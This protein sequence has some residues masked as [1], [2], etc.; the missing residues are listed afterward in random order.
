MVQFPITRFTVQVRSVQAIWNSV[1]SHLFFHVKKKT[2]HEI[3]ARVRPLSHHPVLG[4]FSSPWYRR[5]LRPTHSSRGTTP[6]GSPL[7]RGRFHPDRS[8]QVPKARCRT[9]TH[10]PP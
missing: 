6:R 1:E 2:P 8:I 4:C 3:P 5:F 7:P 10:F 9:E